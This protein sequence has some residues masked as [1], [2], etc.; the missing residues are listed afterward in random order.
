ME[1]KTFYSNKS[2]RELYK[3]LKGSNGSTYNEKVVAQKILE[4]RHFDFNNVE[5][6]QNIWELEKLEK[7]IQKEKEN[8]IFL[9]LW[10]NP[11]F[12]SIFSIGLLVSSIYLIILTIQ[13]FLTVRNILTIDSFVML[14]FV[15][16]FPIIG[17]L[18]YKY[19][20]KRK[21]YLKFRQNRIIELKNQI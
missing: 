7:E 18:T 11:D 16:V 8:I 5:K 6:Y 9:N 17:V 15:I 4:E 13:H 2:D 19:S 12:L 21:K 14:F 3:I 20:R 10:N 1:A